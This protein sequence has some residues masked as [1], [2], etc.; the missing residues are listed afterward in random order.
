VAAKSFN[1]AAGKRKQQREVCVFDAL[2]CSVSHV[3]SVL[4][5]RLRV[6]DAIWRLF[7]GRPP[8]FVSGTLHAHATQMHLAAYREYPSSV[9]EPTPQVD[10]M[11]S[12]AFALANGDAFGQRA[13]VL[14]MLRVCL[15]ATT[16]SFYVSAS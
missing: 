5:G 4:A 14:A 12:E 1:T 10:A 2:P 13:M 6:R 15:G 9:R 11:R 3:D 8:H 7:Q 16:G